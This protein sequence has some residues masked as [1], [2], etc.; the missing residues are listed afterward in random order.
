MFNPSP[1][2][3]TTSYTFFFMVNWLVQ[4][5]FQSI[6]T[7]SIFR[8]HLETFWNICKWVL[9][10][11]LRKL[12][13]P[14]VLTN[15]NKDKPYNGKW[16]E[17]ISHHLMKTTASVLWNIGQCLTWYPAKE[18]TNVIADSGLPRT[19]TKEQKRSWMSWRFIDTA[20]FYTHHGH[21]INIMKYRTI[22]LNLTS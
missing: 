18:G 13:N 16:C 14:L 2:C 21:N 20:I 10:V 17:R 11:C 6:Q 22:L 7:R 3:Q 1:S 8:L 19:K 5:A 12:L 9:I 15:I 4:M